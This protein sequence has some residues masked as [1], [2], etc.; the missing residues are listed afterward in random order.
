M[1]VRQSE[2]DRGLD[3]VLFQAVRDWM[4]SAWPF[5]SVAYPGREEP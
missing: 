3:G 4:G 2:Y 1:W 5:A